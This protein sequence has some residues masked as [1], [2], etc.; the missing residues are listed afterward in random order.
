MD[1]NLTPPDPRRGDPAAIFCKDTAY[2]VDIDFSSL[3]F[4][5]QAV[6]LNSCRQCLF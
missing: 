3:L 1:V 5:A 2:L 6:D 4:T